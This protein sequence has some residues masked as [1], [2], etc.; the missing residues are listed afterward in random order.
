MAGGKG[1]FPISLYPYVTLNSAIFGVALLLFYWLAL[2][3]LQRRRRVHLL[4]CGLLILGTLVS[5]YALVQAGTDSPYVLWWK[6]S[7]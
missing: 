6:K 5:L 3:G 2:Y 7:Y 1:P 4:I